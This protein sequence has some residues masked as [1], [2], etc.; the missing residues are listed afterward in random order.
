MAEPSAGHAPG[1]PWR[2]VA[3]W[4]AVW[5]PF[6]AVA[7]RWIGSDWF[8]VQ[9]QAVLD[10]RL[11]DLG[12]GEPLLVGAFSR[13][14]W[15]HPGPTWFVVLA[16]FRWSWGATGILVGSIAL[17]G[18]GFATL[19]VLTR[20]R[21]GSAVLA[22]VLA[23]L[24]PVLAAAGSFA[25]L[26]P[27]NPH[28]AFAWYPVFL[29]L[30][31][32]AVGR[33]PKDLAIAV[34]LGSL[35]VQLHVG[36][37]P[38]TAV[39]LLAA[40]GLL[41]RRDGTAGLRQH[42]VAGRGWFIATA[43]AYLPVAADQG[44][45]GRDSNLA[46]L[47]RFFLDPPDDVGE[48]TGPSFGAGGIGG[49]LRWPLR[50]LGGHGETTEPFT[51]YVIAE[52]AWTVLPLVALLAAV[53][54]FAR[55]R[56]DR[57]V[58]DSVVVAGLALVAG[59]VALS[60]LL[61][62]RY[63]YLF[64]WRFALVWFVVVVGTVGL[65]R[66]LLADRSWRHER[67]ASTMAAC[68]GVVAVGATVLATSL[69]VEPDEVLPLERDIEAL[70]EAVAAG[71]RPDGPILIVRFDS[72]LEGVADG[73]LNHLDERGWPVGVVE[74]QGFK[75]GEDRVVRPDEAQETWFVT[76]TNLGTTLAMTVP[77]SEVRAATTPLSADEE[78]ELVPLQLALVDRLRDS[79]RLDL[80]SAVDADLVGFAL[81]GQVDTSGIDVDRLSELNAE[82][83]TSGTC[84][85]AVVAVPADTPT[86]LDAVVAAPVGH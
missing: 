4:L 61:G 72:T 84:R 14:G 80:L 16:P 39:P 38:I 31:V 48:P 52:P 15:S 7:C 44:I 57:E 27:W 75:Y 22:V 49:V 34:F 36:Y 86:D 82:I 21:Y 51:G 26:I 19:A 6:A 41:L 29:L 30:C 66:L 76:E 46:Q 63:P 1:R 78:A 85:C 83:A 32:S 59:I 18:A 43:V 33:R 10:L 71:P 8:P 47:G 37:A 55:R 28:L 77:A 54:A 79:G 13:F 23:A 58:L 60:R 74:D 3:L 68:V 65:A 56:A 53:G 2:D 5:L 42:A 24:V 73:L 20:P 35:L 25:L 50:G 45:H 62:E 12:R 64:T 17:Y 69:G 81:D 70:S 67:A 40:V 9:D 11:R